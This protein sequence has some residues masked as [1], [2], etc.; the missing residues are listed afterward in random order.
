MTSPGWDV[1]EAGLQQAMDMF[2]GKVV[3]W[4]ALIQGLPP[5][6]FVAGCLYTRLG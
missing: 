4:G 5:L 6:V 3:W 1:A 2:W